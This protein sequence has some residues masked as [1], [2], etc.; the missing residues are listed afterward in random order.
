MNIS[1]QPIG[2]IDASILEYLRRKL[3]GT[4]GCPVIITPEI[5]IPPHAYRQS[6]R[7]Y[8]ASDFLILLNS[9]EKGADD[10]IIGI[11]DIDLFAP[12]LNFVFGQADM[13]S[14]V[15]IISLYRLKQDLYGLPADE[16]LFL[17][18]MVKE[19]VHELGHTFGLEHCPDRHCIMHFSN[20]LSDTDWKQDS[21]CNQCQPKLIP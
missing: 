7:Q 15:S 16:K 9:L 18:R 5:D 6:R 21:F 12:G 17:E 19:A 1:I 8:V 4:F 3:A 14:G 13:N 10:K 11:V 20:S 2:E